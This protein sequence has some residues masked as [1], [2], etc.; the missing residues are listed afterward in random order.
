ML[1]HYSAY[2]QPR[3]LL[4]VSARNVRFGK[5]NARSL[6]CCA[7]RTDQTKL[8]TNQDVH[9]LDLAQI[10]STIFFSSGK[11]IYINKLVLIS[12][13]YI[14]IYDEVLKSKLKNDLKHFNGH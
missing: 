12:L 10:I 13:D 1:R 9:L 3:S 7:A 11:I 5:V 14:Q 2:D 8:I 4:L 6:S